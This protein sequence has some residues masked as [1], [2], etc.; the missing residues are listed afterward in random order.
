M[1]ILALAALILLAMTLPAQTAE[2]GGKTIDGRRFP[3]KVYS[4][5]TGGVFEA[6]VEFQRDLATIYFVNGG[7]LIIRL[8]QPTIRDPNHIIG[9]GRVGQF[10]LGRS[11]S[12]GIGA[13]PALSGNVTA[14]A[15]TLND[16]WSIRLLTETPKG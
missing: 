7:Q 13:D 14:G 6:Q 11:L 15:G 8:R 4:Y 5:A 1:K 10:P 3:A 12:I 2:Y 16:L 9:Y